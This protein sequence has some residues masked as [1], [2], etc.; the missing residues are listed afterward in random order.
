MGRALDTAFENLARLLRLATPGVLGALA[1]ALGLFPNPRLAI[2]VLNRYALSIGFP[3]LVAYGLVD[4]RLALPTQWAFYLLW[5]LTLGLVLTGVALLLRQARGTVALVCAFGNVAYLGLPLVIA[6]QGDAISGAASLAVTVHVVFAVT[7]GPALL[8][9]WTARE[10]DAEPGDDR[11]ASR[12]TQGASSPR[13]GIW[14]TLWRMPLFWAP[15]A[16]LACRALPDAA[17]A[18]VAVGLKPLAASAAPV[19]IFL[20]GLHLVFERKRLTHVDRSLVAHVVVRLLVLPATAALLAWGAW[21]A[22][23][24]SAPLARLHVTLASMPAAIATFSMAHQLG[25][26][27]QRVA[28][29]IAWTTLLAA[30]SIPAWATFAVWLFGR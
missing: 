4:A 17:R 3:A 22:G 27:A 19:A 13:R 10:L 25:A 9:R 6:A 26:G 1:G 5:P 29:V 8:E 7:A 12:P 2:D 11:A 20:L 14:G 16:G 24:L 30:L 15:W 21:R 23:W 18:E 28:G